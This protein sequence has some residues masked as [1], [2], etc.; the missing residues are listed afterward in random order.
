M[1]DVR[2]N[3]SKE[4]FEANRESYQRYLIEPF[5]RLVTDLGPHML[6]IDHMLDV[7]P[8]INKTISRIYR[9]TRF[10]PD[11]SL[12]RSTMWITFKRHRKEWTDSPGFFFEI[13]PES[14]RYGMGFYSASNDSMNIFRQMIDENSDEFL[15]AISFYA[16][17]KDF[18]VEGEQYKRPLGK[19]KPAVIQEWYNRKNLYVVRNCSDLRRLFEK[20]L[21]VEISTY[22][23]K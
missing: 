6:A 23:L 15:D 18:V 13:T 5:R 16:G 12:Y 4:W 20:E 9:D 17:Q 3:N 21:I 10:S 11:K 8:S 14:Y 7:T 19:D 2:K 22:P 1:I